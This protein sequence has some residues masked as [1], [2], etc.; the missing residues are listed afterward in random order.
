MG[1]RFFIVSHIN[2]WQNGNLEIGNSAV[3]TQ[4]TYLNQI[5]FGEKVME[6]HPDIKH[7]TIVSILEVSENDYND[8]IA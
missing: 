6:V 5:K 3:Y 4:G 8:F 1:K 2:A 7:V